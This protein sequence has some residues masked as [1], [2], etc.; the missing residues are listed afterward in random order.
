MTPKQAAFVR[1]YSIDHNATRAAIRAGYSAKTAEQIGHQL[2]KKSLVKAAIAQNDAEHAER[3]AVT[4]E[5]LTK[6]L[7][8]DRELA[9]SV[10]QPSAAISAVMGKAKL[11]GLL[12]DKS[13]VA[14]T[15][16]VIFKTVYEQP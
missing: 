4:V 14:V 11:H 7:D 9:R 1:E 15:G 16:S 8:K 12:T 2:L 13:E 6:E 10:N 5:S 3:C